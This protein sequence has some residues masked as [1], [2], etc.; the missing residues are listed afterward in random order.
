MSIMLRVKKKSAERT[1]MYLATHRLKRSASAL[2]CPAVALPNSTWDV[3][4]KIPGVFLG[5]LTLLSGIRGGPHRREP[6]AATRAS[7]LQLYPGRD[8][9]RLTIVCHF[10]RSEKS[11]WSLRVNSGNKFPITQSEIL[12]HKRSSK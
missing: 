7:R 3:Q 1:M 5:A 6:K 10:E 2:I 12:S 4:T 9:A 11:P 8:E